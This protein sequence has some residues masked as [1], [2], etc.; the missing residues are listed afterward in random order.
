MKYYNYKRYLSVLF[1]VT[2]LL[3]LISFSLQ[4]IIGNYKIAILHGVCVILQLLNVYIF[5]NPYLALGEG[6]LYINTGVFKKEILITDIT[7]SEETEKQLK[8]TYRHGNSMK[9]QKILLSS[10]YYSEKKQF[11]KDLHS[12]LE[13]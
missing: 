2:C 1:T 9:K 7:I 6:K 5:K 3:F 12:I 11:I 8:F 10:L 4:L 13:I